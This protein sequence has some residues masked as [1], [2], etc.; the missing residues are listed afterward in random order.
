MPAT[1]TQ[2]MDA[3]TI[4]RK[5]DRIAWEIYERHIEEKELFLVGIAENGFILAELIG[6]KLKGISDLKIVLA[7]LEMNKREP[8]ADKTVNLNPEDYRG[9]SIVVVDDVLNSGS[10]LL[11]AV[12]HLLETEV[13][14]CTT[15]V[16]V[17]RN[18]KRFPIKADV[19]GLSLSTSLQEHVEV[20]L[21]SGQIAAYLE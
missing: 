17:D 12:H 1:R 14:R 10:T 21:S 15:A 13:R 8:H 20:D 11:Y 7:R 2:V 9:K 6:E 5:I 16:L 18:H 4:R 3:A 19:K